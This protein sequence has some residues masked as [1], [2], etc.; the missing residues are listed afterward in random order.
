M[1]PIAGIDLKFKYPIL[2]FLLLV[3]TLQSNAQE[4]VADPLVNNSIETGTIKGAMYTVLIPE[5][6]SGGLLL[7]AHGLRP[8]TMPISARLNP[9]EQLYSE[10]LKDGWMVAASSYRRNGY[11]VR[12][13]VDDLDGLLSHIQNEYGKPRRTLI[14][15]SSMGGAIATLIA[16]TRYED[17]DGV[18]AIG[19]AL[20]VWD[21]QRPFQLSHQPHIPI[22]YLSN[23][24]EIQGPRK[25]V[26]QAATAPVIPAVWIV[27]RNGHVNVND[28]ERKSAL[29][30][31]NQFIDT[32]QIERDKDGTVD[33]KL[34]STA[35]FSANRAYSKITSIS[36]VHG[37]IFSGFVAKDLLR[38]GIKN[39]QRF[40]L[41]LGDQTFEVLW[42]NTYRDVG[43]GEWIA[44]ISANDSLMIAVNMESACATLNCKTGDQLVISTIDT[45]E[46]K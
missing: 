1:P 27:S 40:H 24:S 44:Y 9:Q 13:A 36:A 18:L 29:N 16:E 45:N 26:Q 23:Q 14:M 8:D 22:L 25:Y 4:L 10:L 2:L 42:G 28:D 41:S 35:R 11:I 12:D 3:S 21:Q 5:K 32:G 17:Y 7:V 38:I 33:Q 46:E 20:S 19:A 39:G 30:A 15:G 6:W 43:T 31:L 34:S 37:N